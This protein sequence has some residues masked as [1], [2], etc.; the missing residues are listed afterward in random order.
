MY[1]INIIDLIQKFHCSIEVEQPGASLQAIFFVEFFGKI[2]LLQCN[3]N[4]PKC[5]YQIVFTYQVIQKNVFLVS[6]LGIW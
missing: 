1:L 3:I 5:H 2:F 4:W 6:C